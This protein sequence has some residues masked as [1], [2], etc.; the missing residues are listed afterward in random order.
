MLP[1]LSGMKANTAVS[2]VLIGAGVAILARAAEPS[3][4]R[5]LGLALVGAA[6]SIALLTMAQYIFD[7]DLGID[8]LL[9]RQE[10]DVGTIVAGRMSPLTAIC[11]TMLG[12]AALSVQRAP[13][14]VITLSGVALAVSV[15]T[16]FDFGFGAAVPPLLVGFSNMALNTAVAIGIL[17][18]GV[19]GLLGPANP[20]AALA[21]RSPST[22]LLRRLLAVSV[23][24][25]VFMAWLR[26]EGQR[27]GL[28]D[29]SY[30]TSLMLLGILTLGVV[31]ILRSAR[32]ANEMEAKRVALEIERD[33]SHAERTAIVASI[34]KIER[35]DT[36][37]ATA[38]AIVEA[39]MRLP[40][41]DLAAVFACTDR[42][43]EV[44][45]VTGPEGFP[46]RQGELLDPRR[47]RHLLD[48][49]ASG[50]WAERW[51]NDPV[52]GQFGEAFNATGI[53]GQAYAP[54]FEGDVVI[55]AIAIGTLSEAHAEHLLTDL[56]AVA[57][58]AATASV[59]LTPLLAARR[60]TEAA[61][62]AIELI[63]ATGAYRPVFQPI[64]ELETGRTVGFEALTRFADGRRPDLVF[65]AAALAGIGL[66]LE[67]RTLELA[68]RAGHDLP[69]GAWLSLNVSP[70]LIVEA[71]GLAHV[72]AAR[73]RPVVLEITEHVA[74]DDYRA[75]RSAID[76]FGP[77]VRVAVDDAGAGIAN[78]SHLVELRPQLV[79]VDAGLIRDVD[80]DLARQ[81][82]VVGLVH[83]AAKAGCEV[84]AEGIETE[85]ER[86]M[87]FAL[88]VT[89]G[90]GFLIARPA[91][92]GDFADARPGT[93]SPSSL[94]TALADQAAGRRVRSETT[95]VVPIAVAA[96]RGRSG[97][98][99][100]PRPGRGGAGVERGV[101]GG[102]PRGGGGR[103]GGG[104]VG[105][106]GPRRAD[107]GGQGTGP[108]T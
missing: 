92:V 13:R 62:E 97:G 14:T 44:L 30:G 56:P 43:I 11:I 59:L 39:L 72:L 96:P 26:I 48:R 37:K 107:R 100:H 65:A 94:P 10:V 32:W 7:V 16:V 68:V 54:F 49:M 83:F 34:G 40:D 3:R 63:I 77:D 12:L 27:Y 45:A 103:P 67:L 71:A 86:A 75:V 52:Y 23:A 76:R 84:I 42:D 21:G 60:E 106:A 1:G 28:Y 98:E 105:G 36:I 24:A 102:R 61:R 9:F 66:E 29:T 95:D 22:M 80:T 41:V 38:E 69:L 6:V 8:Q 47:A 99:P 82:A 20:F 51:T 58:F 73:D 91:P 79:K 55:G 88:G 25:P 64:V 87:A 78:F 2:L 74:I 46:A 31:A 108:P 18:V 93:R 33:R 104:G 57:E 50:P 5:K 70:G 89:H 4:G 35:K 101:G 90:Q 15:L 85:A 17:A 19:I 81:A 53:T